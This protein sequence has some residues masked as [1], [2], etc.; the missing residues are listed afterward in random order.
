MA[1]RAP[2]FDCGKFGCCGFGLRQNLLKA[3]E[4]DADRRPIKHGF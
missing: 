2:T 4:P 3:S 1:V